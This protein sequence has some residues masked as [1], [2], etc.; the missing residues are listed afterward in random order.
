VL[1]RDMQPVPVGV[2]GDLYV[3]G[4]CVAR[5]YLNRPELTAE[6]FIPNP[7]SRAGGER[8]YWTGDVV[9][10]LA[11]GQIEFLGRQDEQV[12]VHGFR[13][14][15]GEIEAALREHESVEEAVAVARPD[16]HGDTYVAAYVIAAGRQT[17]ISSELSA[18]LKG[19]LPEYMLPSVYLVLDKLPL[20]PHGKVDR[21]VLPE[22]DRR[23]RELEL[24]LVAPRNV[25]EEALAEIF[26]EILGIEQVGIDDNFFALGGHSLLATMVVSR[27][28]TAFK[29]ELPLRRLFEAPTVRALA[30]FLLTNESKPGQTEEKAALL[31]KIES[32]SAD[33]L[34]ELLRRKR[35]KE[36]K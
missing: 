20:T 5:G 29:A 32:L 6:R 24:P 18:F 10:Y 35:A 31:R 3:G 9:R 1:D 17:P 7:F 14:E 21:R 2:A 22:P 4:K 27:L 23:A 8:F 28:R 26:E 34:E 12:K 25:V 33:D 13:I 36:A 19:K 11:D 15:L 16:A 30:E